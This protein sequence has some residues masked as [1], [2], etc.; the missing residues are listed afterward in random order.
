[1]KI[2]ITITEEYILMSVTSLNENSISWE[3]LQKIK[4]YYY[5]DLA[6]VEIYPKQADVVNNANV[7]HLYHIR[8]LK[9][10]NLTELENVKNY[11]IINI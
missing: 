4:E 10:P 8:G 11:S 3:R 5:S 1:M 2:A 7:R 6:F 9:L